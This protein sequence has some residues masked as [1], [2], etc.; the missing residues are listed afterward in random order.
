MVGEFV[1][2]HADDRDGTDATVERG[3]QLGPRIR[4]VE[5]GQHRA[6]CVDPFVHFLD[7]F[8]Q[9]FGQNDVPVEQCGRA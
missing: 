1:A 5:R 6:G 8:V 2:V 4:F 7:R 9:Q 3:L